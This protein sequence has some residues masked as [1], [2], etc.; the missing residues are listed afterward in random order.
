WH[1][2][3][4]ANREVRRPQLGYSDTLSRRRAVPMS[5][6][7]RCRHGADALPKLAVSGARSGV[8]LSSVSGDRRYF[9]QHSMRKN[10]SARILVAVDSVL[11][12]VLEI[13]LRTAQ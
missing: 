12:R 5:A 8:R 3:F 9:C 1:E 11:E 7:F 4:L 13:Y 6:V 10:S 2:R